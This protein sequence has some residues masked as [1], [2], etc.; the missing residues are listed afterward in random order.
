MEG[1]GFMVSRKM[2]HDEQLVYLTGL[3]EEKLNK[4]ISL[5]KDEADKEADDVLFLAGMVDENGNF[6]GPYAGKDYV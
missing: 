5:P 2:T 3:M 6:V 1:S 4:L